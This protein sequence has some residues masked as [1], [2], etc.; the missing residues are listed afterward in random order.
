MRPAPYKWFL[1]SRFRS[2]ISSSGI[3]AKL[4]P[5]Y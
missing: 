2:P 5:Y 3:I 1:R 4:V